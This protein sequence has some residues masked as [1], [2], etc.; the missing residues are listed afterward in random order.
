M[1]CP[2]LS[3]F[4]TEV[5]LSHKSG[6]LYEHKGVKYL[7]KYVYKGHDC[8]NLQ[9][10]ETN[11][12]TH[13]E[14]KMYLDARY[15]SAPEAFWRLSE[16]EMHG[17]SHTIYRLP[18]HL[19]ELQNVYFQAGREE[20]ALDR[21]TSTKLTAWF[22]LN[23]DDTDTSSSQYL[24]TDIPLH[25]AYITKQK[26]WV[27]R[28][29]GGGKIITSMYTASPLDREKFA[30]RCL[31]LHVKGATCFDDLRKHEDVQY[32][33][34]QEACVARGPLEDDQEWDR[35]MADAVALLM[36]QQCRQLFVTI[37]TH[38][39]PSEPHVLWERYKISLSEDFARH[40]SAEVAIECALADIEKR[41]SEA[42]MSCMDRGLPTPNLKYP[43]YR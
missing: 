32:Q 33:S 30:L 2:A 21:S 41:L 22:N 43:K 11:V 12:Y 40:R 31:L 38:C 18:V 17:K 34:F 16:Y 24:Y 29:R 6:S 39:Q 19:P 35:A 25:Y 23:S 15:V 36:P 27:K 28:K 42:G 37:L 8:I 20:E 5:Q 14:I 10:S 13:D 3:Y 7:F 1:G 26:K 9:L 4:I